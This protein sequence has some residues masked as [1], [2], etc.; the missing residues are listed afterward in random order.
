MSEVKITPL[1]RRLAE[2]NGIDWRQI[3]GTGPDGTVVER[4]I[5]AFL[6]KVMAGEVNLPPTPEE[7]APPA[8]VVP[9]MTQA[10]AVLQKEGVQ[11]GDLVPS[12]PS[13]PP[14]PA[15]ALPTLE[16]IEFDL[17]LE[18]TPPPPVP[19]ASAA[20]EEAPTLASEPEIVPNFEE[21]EPLVSTGPLSTLQWEEPE[22]LSP[23]PEV[24]PELASLPPLPS[25]PDLEPPS[26]ANKLIWETQEV[27][28]AP[29]V[30]APAPEPLAPGMSF[31][32]TPEA[33]SAE[34]AVPPAPEHQ[35]PVEAAAAPLTPPAASIPTPFANT[36]LGVGPAPS[37]QM[38]RV[39]AW[40]RLV[41]IGPAQEAAQTLSE[42]WRMEVG[43]D[44][45]LYRAADKALSDTQTPLR[46]TK[47]HLEGNELK[48][49]RVAPAQSL[50]GTLDSLR[51]ASD[52]AEGLVVLSLANSAFDQVIF[53]GLSTLTL[54]RANAGHALL[55]LS[56]DISSELAA[57]LLERVAYYLERPILLA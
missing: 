32:N 10:Q 24:N 31:T 55:T 13:T 52:P 12:S 41:A 3:K 53:P 54:G 43:L 2:E 35:A 30:P 22:P 49:L 15:S 29:E 25:E 34:P 50:R 5:L 40:Q 47:G 1:A 26:S 6:A 37:T 48:S 36:G 46:P 21:P 39:Q 8:S 7:T 9:D 14:P 19:P 18:P 56:G 44:A 20:F 38:L 11:L 51:M 28:T 57:K 16:D 45:L 23:L 27:L 33:P 42:A 17:D 4:D